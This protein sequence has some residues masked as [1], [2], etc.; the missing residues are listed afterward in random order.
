M[1]IE[2]LIIKLTLENEIYK[3]A[4]LKKKCAMLKYLEE[5]IKIF[6]EISKTL[7]NEN[8]IEISKTFVESHLKFFYPENDESESDSDSQTSSRDPLEISSSDDLW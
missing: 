8:C 5:R 3:K 7:I 1:E 6:N 4:I 2:K